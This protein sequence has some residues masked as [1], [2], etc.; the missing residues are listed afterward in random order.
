MTFRPMHT[1][2]TRG[3]SR[4]VTLASDWRAK[5]GG[6]EFRLR[7]LIAGQELNVYMPEDRFVLSIGDDDAYVN[8]LVV[9]E[10]V[11]ET[12]EMPTTA[13]PLFLIGLA[14]GGFLALGGL[15]STI[16]RRRA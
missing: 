13:S 11:V 12:T 2:G 14:G 10:T 4:S 1:D 16:R 15:L 6:R 5:I 8:E 7:D 9:V 3:D